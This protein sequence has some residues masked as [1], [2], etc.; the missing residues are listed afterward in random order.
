MNQNLAG[1][2]IGMIVCFAL[3]FAVVLTI[4]ILF[5]LTLHRTMKEVHE[6]NREFSPGMVWLTL[7][8]LFGMIWVILMVPKIA[9]SLRRE[10]EDR[11]WRTADENFG[12]TVGMIW[13]WGA[14]VSVALSIMQNVAR[15]ADQAP[16][17]MVIGLL[18]LPVSLGILVC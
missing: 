4:Q 13:A 5:L 15:A 18:S 12:R 2:L 7:I 17:A 1:V 16:V 10:Y 6:R 14:V 8:P 3:V 9:T 11:G